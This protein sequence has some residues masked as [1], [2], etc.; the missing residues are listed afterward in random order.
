MTINAPVEVDLREIV[1]LGAVDSSLFYRTFFPGTC[2]LPSPAMHREIDGVIDGT[3]RLVNILMSR[4]WAKTSKLKMYAGKRIAYN[5]S[6]T[7]LFVGASEKHTRRSIRWIRNQIDRNKLFAET[8]QLRAGTP[9]TDEEAQIIHGLDGN[10][11]WITGVGVSSSSGRGINFDDHRPDLI[12]LDDIMNDENAATKEG[13]E[14]IIDLVFGA[15]LESLAPRSESPFA[16][17]V[18]LNTPQNFN[19]ISQ[20]AFKDEA[21]VSRRYGCWTPETE[22]AALEDRKSAWEEHTSTED[23]QKEYQQAAARNRLSIFIREKECKL[24]SP[25]NSAFKAAWLRYFGKDEIT[26][27]PPLEQMWTILVI[28]PIPPPSEIKLA[29]G[30]IDSD[31]EALTVLGKYQGKV[32]VLETAYSRGNDPNWTSSEFFR[33]VSKWRVRKALIESVVF[34]KTVAWYLREQM[35]K[36]GIYVL[37]DEFGRGDRRSK[38]QKILDGITGIAS[39]GQLYFRRDQT[40]AI[41]QFTNFSTIRKIG[42]DDVLETIAVGCTELMNGGLNVSGEAIDLEEGEFADLTDYRGAP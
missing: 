37:L 35:R 14:K 27:E 21:F 39:N 18:M 26:I 3:N 20:L 13:R 9:W 38:T 34:S 4:G 25:E 40:E 33:L 29:K 42:H 23:L 28:D 16:K 12:I 30:I 11:I 24:T 5:L 1:R 32:F 7:I 6:R 41:S 17:L 36:A 15:F 8:F 19:D 10:S 31:Y 2:R 22:D